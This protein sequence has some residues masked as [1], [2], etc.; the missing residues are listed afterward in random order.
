MRRRLAIGQL[1][2][3][4][5]HGAGH[6]H[7]VGRHA[8]IVDLAGFAIDNAG[9]LTDVNAHGQHRAL[10]DDDAFRHLGPGANEAV[11][12]DDDRAGLQGL[13]H[14]ADAGAAGNVHVLADL[15]AGADGGPGIDH[16]AGI[17]IGAKVDKGRHEHHAGGDVGRAAH[18]TG[19]NGAEAGAAEVFLRPALELGGHLVPPGRPARAAGDERHVIEAEGEKHR[20]FQPLIDHPLPVNFLGNAHLA[21]IEQVKGL[22]HGLANLAGGVRRDLIAVFESRLNGVLQV[23]V[24]HV[25][26]STGLSLV[27]GSVIRLAPDMRRRNDP[28]SS[29]MKCT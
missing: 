18:D 2:F 28:R 8:A 14:T 20:L 26:S 9:G 29:V 4:A 19:G 23:F 25:L 7:G 1:G 5:G 13:E 6:D 16:G 21:G 24:A 3:G 15:G 10:A 27:C 12:L 17:D 22:L 11:V